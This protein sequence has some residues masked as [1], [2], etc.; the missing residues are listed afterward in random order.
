MIGRLAEIH[1][2]DYNELGQDHLPLGVG[3]LDVKT[4]CR[5]IVDRRP[6]IV[7]ENRSVRDIKSSISH[8]KAVL[9]GLLPG[10]E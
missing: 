6:L 3:K 4:L 1:P 7:V 10:G 2:H 9:G 5:I 8:L